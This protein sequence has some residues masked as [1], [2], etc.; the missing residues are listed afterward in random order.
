MLA[1][2]VALGFVFPAA[3]QT[4]KRKKSKKPVPAQCSGCN[5]QTIAPDIATSSADDAE[6]LTQLSELA[7]SLHNAVPGSYE[8][9][10]AFATKH[11]ND[12][13]GARAAL[14]LGY[15]DYQRNRTANA[16]TWLNK[17]KG[18]AV[19]QE[20][21]L[22]WRAQTNRAAKRNADAYADLQKLL[23]EFP[24][25]AIKE[26]VLDAFTPVAIEL[27][28]A[29]SAVDALNGYSAANSK[30]ALLLD[31][32]QAY[33]SS[34]QPARAVKDYQTI[35]YKYPL[36]DEAKAAGGALPGLQKTL[37]SEFPYGTGEMQEQR[38][39]AFFDARKW[40]EAR[41]EFEKLV[42]MLKDTSNP[43]RQR[44]QLRVAQCRVQLKSPISLVSSL[45]PTDPDVD[46]E[47]LYAVSQ[48]QRSAKNES[49]MLAAIEEIAQKYADSKWA[50][51]A[52]MAAGN[53]YWVGLDRNKAA[54]YY[55]R[56]LDTYPNSKNDFNAEW[57]IAWVSYLNRA[58]DSDDRF[59]TFLLKYPV[60]SNSVDAL[61]WLGRNAE[62]GGNPGHA[63]AFYAKAVERYPQTYFG[64]AAAARLAKL[65]QT[66][67]DTVDFL[68]KIPPPPALR[69]FDEPIPAA[70]EDRWARA[71][72]L[73]SIAFDS[74]AEQELKSAFFAT[75]SPRFLL[76]A[77]QAAFD[78]GHYATGMAYARTIVPS[79]DS[80]NFNELPLAVWKA[81]YPLPYESPVRKESGKNDLDPAVVAGLIR[82]EST[83]QADAVSHA[84]AY[85]LMQ[86]LPKTAKLLSK[87]LRVRYN[88]KLLYSPN[89][90]I[91]LGTYYFKGLVQLT[92]APEY[93][94][95]AYNAG[96]DRIA[97]W[98]SERAYDEIPELVES[99]PFTETREYVQIV[100]RNAQLYRTIYGSG[101]TPASTTAAASG[102]TSHGR[103]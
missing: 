5:P 63:R 69:P 6:A 39:Q 15:D 77:A 33:R 87:Q 4:K 76:G 95:A 82:Q 23:K 26:Q 66:D 60:S 70:A 8:K 100:L 36:A 34:G 24:N 90:N 80:R 37:R 31:R 51:E 32:A 10:S 64:Y 85:G 1:L 88:K 74:F 94:L 28:H 99:I 3:A 9:L 49:A 71:Q 96:E 41:T 38:A 43:V 21:V 73:R 2:L 27:G 72:A 45:K 59:R 46:A 65:P 67:P 47:R 92:G 101:S 84:N 102:S 91:Q 12:V 54:S 7:R 40:R 52:L 42:S 11:A 29:Q 13:W 68:D 93:A 50:D 81:L 48:F 57:R 61:Y 44:A 30:P 53:Y 56:V 79:F 18:D 89:Y 83:F 35:F 98:K 22:Y 20:Y 55:Q 62:T 19:L 14:A 75:G 86:L 97:L 58:A 17:A 25:T 78:Q 103:R 16:A